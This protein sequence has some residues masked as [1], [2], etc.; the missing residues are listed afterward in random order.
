MSRHN[1]RSH[2]LPHH[3]NHDY[4]YQRQED[5]IYE[6]VDTSPTHIR[7]GQGVWPSAGYGAVEF[8][9]N[10]VQPLIPVRPDE[11]LTD[12]STV[13]RPQLLR[14]S[15]NE[16]TVQFK[17]GQYAK[18]V[19][20]ILF[21]SLLPFGLCFLAFLPLCTK[22]K[23]TKDA[24][25]VDPVSNNIV[26]RFQRGTVDA[27]QMI[28]YHRYPPPIQREQPVSQQ[29]VGQLRAIPQLIVF[30]RKPANLPN[31][32]S[33]ITQ[34]RIG[35]GNLLGAFIVLLVM[36][37][38]PFGWV[39]LPVLTLSCFCLPCLKDVE[40]LHPQTGDIMGVYYQCQS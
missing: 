20:V 6:A 37:F 1:R 19:I 10:N 25:H 14:E 33:T 3:S 23:W 11:Q 39:L 35:Y 8:H 26:G 24:Y 9:P 29:A 18:M 2:S 34:K 7:E 32:G 22:C 30:G 16:T 13:V 12:Y 38:V 4:Q 27:P 5:T 17:T 31:I 21:F 15:P 40:H 28:R 36:F